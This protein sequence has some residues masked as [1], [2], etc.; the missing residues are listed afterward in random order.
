[1]GNNGIF[2][3]ATPSSKQYEPQF[4]HRRWRFPASSRLTQKKQKRA[5]LGWREK[6]VFSWLKYSSNQSNFEGHRV[7]YLIERKIDQI[8][9]RRLLIIVG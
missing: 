2:A 8:F 9:S 3:I 4:W 5:Q 6:E 7:E 1:M